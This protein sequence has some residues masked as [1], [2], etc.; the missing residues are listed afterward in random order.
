M[1]TGIS[2]LVCTQSRPLGYQSHSVLR[3]AECT[4]P[5]PPLTVAQCRCETQHVRLT[6]A[7]RADS[8]RDQDLQPNLPAN[9]LVLE[10][11]L[12]G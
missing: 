5:S 2:F 8:A 12:R 3:Q 11:T 10:I 4:R 1:P 6:L 9:S 7:H